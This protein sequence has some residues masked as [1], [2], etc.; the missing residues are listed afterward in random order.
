MCGLGAAHKLSSLT[1]DSSHSRPSNVRSGLESTLVAVMI[2]TFWSKT[3]MRFTDRQLS[4]QSY[5]HSCTIQARNNDGNKP[6]GYARMRIWLAH[7]GMDSSQS[8]NNPLLLILG[9]G[10]WPAWEFVEAKWL[11][12]SSGL[13]SDAQMFWKLDLRLSYQRP[14]KTLIHYIHMQI[15]SAVCCPA[16]VIMQSRL[17]LYL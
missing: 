7:S 6:I 17:S 15:I 9:I 10:A 5:E 16:T 4:S 1:S 11:V 14:V 2:G 12:G 13:I 8:S 3:T